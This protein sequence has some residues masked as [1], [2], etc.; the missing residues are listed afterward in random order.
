MMMREIWDR[1]VL[2]VGI[3]VD[4]GYRLI[5]V[6]ESRSGSAYAFLKRRKGYRMK[7]PKLA[8]RVADHY[9]P[10]RSWNPPGRWH[11]VR[12]IVLDRT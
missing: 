2:E 5:G 8:I 11:D 3:A 10:G 4:E 12:E 7:R 6:S 9:L 1:L